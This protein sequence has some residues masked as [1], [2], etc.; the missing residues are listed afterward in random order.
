MK[1]F[2]QYASKEVAADASRFFKMGKGEYAEGDVFLGIRSPVVRKFAKENVTLSLPKVKT[3]IKSRF[4][5]ERLLGLI[6][7]VNKY[8]KAC[9]EEKEELYKL[10]VE[11][12]KYINNWDLIDVT[13]PHIIGVHLM[14]RKRD[15]LYKWVRSKD[16]WI[17][18]IAMMV[19]WWFIR[20]G[21]LKEVFKM[22]KILLNDEHDLIHKSVGWML[23]EAYKKD[24]KA[25][26]AF[27]K[28][29]YKKMPRVM[30]RY[31]IEKHPESLRKG[32]LLGKI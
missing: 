9:E 25:A 4:H 15:V 26:D 5:E 18:R 10:Y 24:S 31:A 6:I 2:R 29:Y 22:A 32:Y 23:R 8:K 28:K 3:L 19:N 16:L 30:L 1:S 21:D 7:I 11:H 20:Q 17:K 14:N 27:L 13:C 12:F